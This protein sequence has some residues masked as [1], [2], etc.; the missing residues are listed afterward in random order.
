MLTRLLVNEY[1]TLYVE[2]LKIMIL[3]P[4]YTCEMGVSVLACVKKKCRSRLGADI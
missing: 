4:S 2:V 3:F 1:P